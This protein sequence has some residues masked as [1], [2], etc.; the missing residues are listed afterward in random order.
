VASNYN[1]VSRCYHITYDH[2][3]VEIVEVVVLFLSFS[4]STDIPTI[5]EEDL[6]EIEDGAVTTGASHSSASTDSCKN[7]L[8]F[9]L[10]NSVFMCAPYFGRI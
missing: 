3:F 7:F 1:I 10:F 8:Y 4:G 2:I 6:T 5:P 9:E